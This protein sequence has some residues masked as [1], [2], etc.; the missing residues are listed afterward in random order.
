M[1]NLF[2]IPII[3]R[4][5]I[6]ITDDPISGGIISSYFNQE[7]EY[8]A[9]IE[10][11]RLARPDA[12]NEIIKRVNLIARIK[13]EV[14]IFAN[15]TKEIIGTIKKYFPDQKILDIDA[16]N[17]IDS[18]LKVEFKCDNL[19][20]LYCKPEEI[21]Y[22]S[23]LAK[24]KKNHL[25]I[26]DNAPN[27]NYFE[28]NKLVSSGH[29]VT[30][31]DNK[32]IVPIIAVNYAY[33]INAKLLFLPEKDEEEIKIIYKDIANSRYY[34]GLKR[35]EDAN[36][37]LISQQ[38]NYESYFPGRK[39]DASFITFITKGIPYGYFFPDIPSAHL[40]SYPDLGMTISNNLYYSNY[41]KETRSALL[42]DP[43][44]FPENWGQT[45]TG[46]VS[47]QLE[48]MG[49]YTK[50][51]RGKNAKVYDTSLFIE[52][53]PYDLLYICSHAG[54][55][56]GRELKIKFLDRNGNEHRIVIEEAVSFGLTHEGVGDD[57]LVEVTNFINFLSID[58]FDWREKI[59]K[60]DGK[61]TGNTIEDFLAIP[62]EKWQVINKRDIPF[63]NNS[64]RIELADGDSQLVFHN[65]S[66][67]GLPIIFN[68]AC[69]SFYSF[70]LRFLFA[71]ARSYIGT[72]A[73]INT[74]K[75]KEIAQLFFN[76][77]SVSKPLPIL[78][79]EIQKKCFPNP[80]ERVY[81][82]VGTHFCNMLPPSIDTNIY[83]NQRIS[84]QIKRLERQFIEEK[85]R[86]LNRLKNVIKF[87]KGI[88]S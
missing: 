61:I 88:I 54:R 60:S 57:R 53:F 2:K 73:P 70:A 87:L 27:L 4:K 47:E 13:P 46:F 43:D 45:E 68:N 18:L 3:H 31:D 16:I 9:L 30:I 79:W 35:G 71:G 59:E 69:V 14:I 48:K 64:I 56:D 17:E 52:W 72:L 63:V 55:M 86:D 66:G 65:V 84:N 8:F 34:Q 29:L 39:I 78:L 7:N 44:V 36:R 62:R 6:C 80:I 74:V 50:E 58:G 81:I 23:L 38:I 19:E 20:K 67:M 42:V 77:L 51:L 28:I 15:I 83:V 33:S 12:L 21:V 85:P 24:F 11:P 5:A 25:F 26:D 76:S 40:F 10:C 49:V 82:F 1:A 37:S 41:I 22:G 75:A 32:G